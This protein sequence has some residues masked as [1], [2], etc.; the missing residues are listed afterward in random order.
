MFPSLPFKGDAQT[1]VI[2]AANFRG[3]LRADS[4]TH[5]LF[6]LDAAPNP[7]N[8]LVYL[9]PDALPGKRFAIRCSLTPAQLGN[10]S[11]GIRV[12]FPATNNGLDAANIAY[13]LYSGSNV[14][15]WMTAGGYWVADPS[16]FGGMFP[17]ANSLG[18]LSLGPAAN[19]TRSG[20]AVGYFANGSDRGCALGWGATGN[21]NGTGVGTNASGASNGVGIGNAAN[22]NTSGVAIGNGANGNTNG[23]GIGSGATTNSMDAAVVLGMNSKAERYREL[24]K[25]A[26]RA[27]TCLRSFSILDWYGD[28]TNATP[29]EL[30]LGGTASQRAL[31]LNSSAF[32]FKLLTVARDNVL[33][34]CKCWEITGGIKRGANAAATALVGT[35]TK[36]VIGADTDAATWDLDAVADA[37]NG[38]LKL[39]VTGEAAK[40]IRW[41]VRGDIS[42][43]RF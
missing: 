32:I 6:V 33:G 39:N 38:S 21:G 16:N 2:G 24:V 35:I 17:D 36:T 43:L 12:V 40:T 20:V 37:T 30:L 7:A 3:Y 11:A 18:D 34:D 29:A 1:T 41:N 4:P 42:E 8:C 31:L 9:P 28:T 23:V 15:F 14:V 5:Q 25:S 13:D 19:G 26:D 27:S 22:G 10:Y